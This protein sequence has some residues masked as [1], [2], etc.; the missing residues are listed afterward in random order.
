MMRDVSIVI[1]DIVS[2]E[3]LE[4]LARRVSYGLASKRHDHPAF[5]TMVLF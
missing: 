4:F 3:W 2:T 1:L 5:T